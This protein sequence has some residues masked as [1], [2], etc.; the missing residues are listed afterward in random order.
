MILPYILSLIFVIGLAL[1]SLIL[2]YAALVRRRAADAGA[3]PDSASDLGPAATNRW[4][5]AIRFVF[6]A[7]CLIAIGFHAYWA[8]FAA[9]P[10]KEDNQY[11]SIKGG[12]DRRNLR[13]QEG[14]L[15][16][17][18]FD[19]R[20]NPDS[21]LIRY[22]FNGSTIDRVYPLGA[23]AVHL[24]GY[25][26]LLFGQGGFERAYHEILTEPVSTYNQFVSTI[27]VGKDIVS[28]LHSDLQ[29][30]ASAQLR[31]TRAGAAV[32]L[33]VS[34]GEVLAMA[35]WPTYD[36]TTIANAQ[37]WETMVKER[38]NYP[39]ISP[40]VNRALDFY[41]RP[42][43]TFKVFTSAV[44]AAEGKT[45]EFFV[46]KPEGY[47]APQSGR[48]IRDFEGGVHGRI[49]FD[50][51]LRVSCNQYFAQ[52]G[53]ALGRD[54]LAKHAKNF[55]LATSL[56][57][58]SIRDGEIWE[59][60][61]EAENNFVKVFGP[62]QSRM[63][64]TREATPF[65][66]A[67]QAFGQGYDDMT[68][69]EMALLAATVA[70]G[71]G[72]IPHLR[73]TTG[74]PPTIR[75]TFIPPPAA[76]RVRG[77]MRAVVTNGSG[78]GA[79]AGFPISVAGKTGTA[80]REVRQFDPR[81][82]TPLKRRDE[83]GNEYTISANQVDAWFIGFAPFENPRIA[84]AV[85]VEGGITG[86]QSAAPIARNLIAKAAQL[87]LLGAPPPPTNTTS[88]P[89]RPRSTAPATGGVR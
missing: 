40:L 32:V 84:F 21:T 79:F 72:A 18:V 59:P 2:L 75:N 33:D 45:N 35:T 26:S 41:Y 38:D 64:L 47:T 44:A 68:V 62:P 6:A 82:R 50:D 58:A 65:D 8:L 74:Q 3:G 52:L 69:L 36:P 5:R 27:P 37:Q 60:L 80:D 63:N 34:T 81:T 73:F 46:C 28:S 29:R 56:K 48:P 51:A 67:L 39:E 17:W 12:R 53:L 49:G 13:L 7:A 11:L 22:H 83:K 43:S 61:A 16:G 42:G 19:R 70:R 77:M 85:V 55:G 23:A 78:A 76:A 87:G 24:T 71:D 88:T 14:G 89:A 1:I 20:N 15:R 57:D 30:E 66:I 31:G 86:G 9:G 54:T 25:S 4:L 10:L